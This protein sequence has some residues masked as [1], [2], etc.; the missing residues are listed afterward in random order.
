MGFARFSALP[1]VIDQPKKRKSKKLFL[2]F[3]NKADSMDTFAQILV[4]IDDGMQPVSLQKRATCRSPSPSA[5]KTSREK[6][7]MWSFC[8]I[9]SK[10]T[11][12]SSH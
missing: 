4:N 9:L 3:W 1:I 7:D 11:Q 5:W 10:F 12:N 2:H 8:K 6:K